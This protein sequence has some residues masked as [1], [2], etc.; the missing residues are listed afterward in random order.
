MLLSTYKVDGNIIIFMSNHSF[1]YLTQ[2]HLMLKFLAS[3][4]K[5][6]RHY[7]E[8]VVKLALQATIVGSVLIN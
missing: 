7:H 6:L 1:I 2:S 3:F 5:C 4:L 8:V